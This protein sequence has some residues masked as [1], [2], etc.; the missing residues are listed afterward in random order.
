MIRNFAKIF[1]LPLA[2][3]FLNCETQVNQ[4]QNT[5]VVIDT[6]FEQPIEVENEYL[7]EMDESFENIKKLLNQIINDEKDAI[8]NVITYPLKRKSPLP[9]IL[10]KKEFIAN[11]DL[12]FDENLKGILRDFLNEPDFIDK[13]GS[14]GL[15]GISA[16]KIW[17]NYDGNAIIRFNYISE[18]EQSNRDKLEIKV[19]NAVHPILKNYDYNQY[20]GKTDLYLFRIDVTEKGLRYAQWRSDQTMANEPDFILFD[21][22]SNQM[23]SA[24]GWQ[25]LFIKKDRSYILDE[26]AICGDIEDC[27]DF[28]IIQN[29]EEVFYKGN[30]TEILNPFDVLPK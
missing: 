17:F 19:K 2:L 21:G 16:G 10:N 27:G 6:I 9:P 15:I 30:V 13:T 20:L 23:G 1:Y 22:E 7:S 8:A 18:A 11:W 28:L 12:L 26:V 24:G 25:T 4:D 3:V 5:S 14:N 29:E